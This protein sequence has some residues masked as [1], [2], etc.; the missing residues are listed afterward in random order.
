MDFVPKLYLSVIYASG[1]TK[2]LL[3]RIDDKTI[4]I[5]MDMSTKTNASLKSLKSAFG[6]EQL[7][8]LD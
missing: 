6:G 4:S 5:D 2:I 8:F 1:V 3:V 7:L